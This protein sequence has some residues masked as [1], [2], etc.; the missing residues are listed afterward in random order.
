MIEQHPERAQ[1]AARELCE[2][3]E[4]A[5]LLLVRPRE[6]SPLPSD[7]PLS[8]G[9][10]RG[11]PG[12]RGHHL[13]G[14]GTWRSKSATRL[15]SSRT[16]IRSAT[17]KTLPRLWLITTTP[18]PRSARRFSRASTCSVWGTPSAAVG[19]S[20]S[21]TFGSP[22]SERAIATDW[23]WP[24]ER[25]PT[26][27]RTLPSVVTERSSS[28]CSVRCSMSVSSRCARDLDRRPRPPPGRGR[29]WRRRRGCRRGRGPGRRW[30]CRAR[31][32]LR[33]GDLHLPPLE[34]HLAAVGRLD[35]VHRLHQG[36]LAG[37]VVADQ[38]RPPRR[39]STSKSTSVRRLDRPEALG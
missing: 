26:S 6:V 11:G 34:V 18:R 38:R 7:R 2:E 16:T 32:R 22:T 17:W 35:A 37:A 8:L 3:R 31:G 10:V 20:K 24:P 1:L 12:D 36:R 5:L 23:R 15:P 39:R 30:R 27:V 19:S 33:V 14:R 25:L 9:C 4:P 29:G 13:L 28:S 21:T